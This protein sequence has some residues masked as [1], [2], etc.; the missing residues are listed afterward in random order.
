MIDASQGFDY[1]MMT[2]VNHFR[3]H[4]LVVDAVIAIVISA[5]VPSIISAIKHFITDTLSKHLCEFIKKYYSMSPAKYHIYSIT[6]EISSSADNGD[7]CGRPTLNDTENIIIPLFHKL[8]N[9]I[10]DSNQDELIVYYDQNSNEDSDNDDDDKGDD[11]KGGNDKVNTP[12]RQSSCI[13]LPIEN[14]TYIKYNDKL[15]VNIEVC[16]ES[17]DSGNN[18]R[19]PTKTTCISIKIRSC[20]PDANKCIAQFIDDTVKEYNIIQNN[21]YIGPNLFIY[22]FTDKYNKHSDIDFASVKIK[23]SKKIENVYIPDSARICTMLAHFQNKTGI[24]ANPG[25]IHKFGLLL[26]GPPGTGKTSMIKAIANHLNRSII[27][28]SLKDIP[29]DAALYKVFINSKCYVD[30]YSKKIPASSVIYVFE[31]IDTHSVLNKRTLDKS[32]VTKILQ[33]ATLDAGDVDMGEIVNKPDRDYK[34]GAFTLGGFLNVLDGVVE[35]S[36]RVVIMTT[37]CLEK[38]DPAVYRPG[39][40]NICAKLGYI[41]DPAI[42]ANICRL[43]HLADLPG[44]SES[45]MAALLASESLQKT[46]FDSAIVNK[47]YDQRLE[48]NKGKLFAINGIDID[49]NE[50]INKII[51]DSLNN[52]YNNVISNAERSYGSNS[53]CDD[54]DC[55]CDNNR[56][57]DTEGLDANIVCVDK[58]TKQADT[59]E[60]GDI[61]KQKKLEYLKKLTELEYNKVVGLTASRLE[62]M[63]FESTSIADLHQKYFSAQ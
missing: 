28:I 18:K 21:K 14:G 41:E 5:L 52:K 25:T 48:R 16:T 24:Y 3:T 60:V 42:F 63:C 17:T 62:E 35:P 11:D 56:N 61:I 47:E 36:N 32:A 10:I 30:H 7:S 31:D 2:F 13:Y 26:H 54:E 37:N 4:N 33:N 59:V 53:G 8:K 45:D 57:N 49:N 19:G 44:N 58:D 6:T 46:L 27:Y 43:H 29:S 34:I 51:Q 50:Q 20:A 12:N 38:L 1:N 55:G 9:T 40:V 22:S 15:D 39:R 23:H